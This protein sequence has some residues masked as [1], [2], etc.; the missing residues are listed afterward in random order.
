MKKEVPGDPPRQR[1]PA[2]AEG[3][4]GPF[5]GRDDTPDE[6]PA[7][8]VRKPGGTAERPARATWPARKP[9]LTSTPI[10]RVLAL[11]GTLVFDVLLMAF[12]IA[13]LRNGDQDLAAAA[14][15]PAVGLAYL[16]ARQLMTI[17]FGRRSE[18]GEVNGDEPEPPEAVGDGPDDEPGPTDADD[19]IADCV[20]TEVGPPSMSG[21]PDID[22]ARMRAIPR[23][24]IGD[25][26]LGQPG[27]VVGQPREA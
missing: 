25:V 5:R 3:P 16:A 26:D 17:A 27:P 13:L 12:S 24:P 9:K 18:D 14:A 7:A 20:E 19:G 21:G 22:A 6:K 2:P 8:R 23:T 11:T 15:A 4:V 10:P 1:R